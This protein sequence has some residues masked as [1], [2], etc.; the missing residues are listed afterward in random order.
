MQNIYFA[1]LFKAKLL[2]EYS[3]DALKSKKDARIKNP[4]IK[5]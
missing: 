3:V 2:K 1:S 5:P 4:D